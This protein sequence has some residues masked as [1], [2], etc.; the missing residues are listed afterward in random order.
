M[1]ISTG[2]FDSIFFLGHTPFLNL[3]IWPKLKIYIYRKCWFVLFKEQIISLLIFGQNYFVQ[4]RWN[5]FSVRL[6]VTN[7][8]NCH[9]LYTAFSSNV[10]AWGMSACSLF[11]SFFFIIKPSIAKHIMVCD[12]DGWTVYCII[13]LQQSDQ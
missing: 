2:N 10:G 5:W 8:W 4:L 13:L 9:S 1:L 6:P 12:A 11:L 7:A 3:E